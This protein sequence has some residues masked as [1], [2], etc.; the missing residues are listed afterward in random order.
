MKHGEW[1]VA[2]LLAAA[3]ILLGACEEEAP[4]I[5]EQIRAIKTFTVTE[6]ASGQTLKYSGI[7]QA[8]DTSA[9][10]FQVSGNVGTVVAELGDRVTKGQV[11]AVLDSAPYELNLQAAN[12]EL[13]NA[14]SAF[15]EAKLEYERKRTL[16]EK[17]WVAKAA[18][19]QTI[20][21]YN[22][23]KSQ[24][25]Y[26]VSKAN[27][28]KRDLRLTTL[29]APFAGV[30]AEKSID[31]YVE[32]RAGQ[33]L[34]EI[35][36]EG[37]VEVALNI[38]ETRI[39]KIILGMPVSV[40]LLTEGGWVGDGR[41]TEVGSVAGEANAF[42]VKAGLIDP[43]ANI[44]SGM[45]AEVTFFIARD[46]DQSA[47]LVPLVAILPIEEP[48]QGFVFVYD[49]ESGTVQR[50]Q[51]RGRGGTDN[52]V[53]IFDGVSAGDVIAVAGVSFLSDGQKVKLLRP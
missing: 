4:E 48:R 44:R 38:P 3:A 7:V 9:L 24:V 49:A 25:D 14:R 39:D 23:A 33:K 6:V 42:P 18:L 30:I 19:D 53:A 28:A 35:N 36:A 12:A 47:Y 5:A 26:A 13:Q 52:M 37:A 41:I 46:D 20:A 50:R 17:G 16:Y 27:L 32:V 45:T 1:R 34:F 15:Q 22:S 21:S 40:S 51:V 8:T 11:L 43:P 31:P 10:S 29:T 2:P